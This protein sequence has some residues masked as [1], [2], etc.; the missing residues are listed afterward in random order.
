M[1]ETCR[2]HLWDKIIVKLFASSWYIFLTY[3]YDARSHLYQI[4]TYLGI[5]DIIFDFSQ[6]LEFFNSFFYK[7]LQYQIWRK[8]V[9]REAEL[10]R[11]GNQTGWTDIHGESQRLFPW[12]TRKLVTIS[13]SPN[14]HRHKHFY[15]RLCYRNLR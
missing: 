2:G 1:S 7:S 4:N 12:I 14:N 13:S 8:S 3:I 15:N 5:P 9:Q 11:P 10:S 6:Y